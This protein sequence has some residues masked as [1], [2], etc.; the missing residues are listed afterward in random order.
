MLKTKFCVNFGS[1]P[2]LSFLILFFLSPIPLIVLD[3]L[4]PF[5]FIFLLYNCFC[6]KRILDSISNTFLVSVWVFVFI[7]FLEGMSFES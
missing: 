5:F 2:E 4:E 7:F 3:Y 6:K 1:F